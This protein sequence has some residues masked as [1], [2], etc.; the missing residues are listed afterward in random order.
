MSTNNDLLT[1]HDRLF[2]EYLFY[3][4]NFSIEKL[5][6]ANA[7]EFKQAIIN[8]NVAK[9]EMDLN[10]IEYLFQVINESHKVSLKSS[11]RVFKELI[12]DY[13]T[14]LTGNYDLV[15]KVPSE[16]L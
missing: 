2:K 12:Y 3:I 15:P 9:K 5:M 16:D 7:E 6:N 8:L 13:H 1:E 10:D 11:I 4:D 14:W